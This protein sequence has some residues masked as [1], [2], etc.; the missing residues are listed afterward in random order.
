MLELII[1]AVL[2]SIGSL[3][4][5]HFY[6]RKSSHDLEGSIVLLKREIEYLRN[7]TR[8]LQDASHMISSDTEI[9]RKRVVLGTLEDPEYPYK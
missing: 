1:G 6:Y 3:V 7:V 2:G 9:I 8:E 5:A 4:I